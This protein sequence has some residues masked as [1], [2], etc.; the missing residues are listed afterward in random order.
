MLPFWSRQQ[1]QNITISENLVPG[2][3]VAQ[4]H[5]RGFDVR[6]E[7]VSPVPCRLFSI[8]C[9]EGRGGRVRGWMPLRLV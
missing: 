6:Y 4:V 5:A 2:S 8:G 7:I 1:A 9:G 3:K